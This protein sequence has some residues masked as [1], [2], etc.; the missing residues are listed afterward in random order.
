M[1]DMT[2][3]EK[4]DFGVQHAFK[5]SRGFVEMSIGCSKRQM[6]KRVSHARLM[7]HKKLLTVALKNHKVPKNND[8]DETNARKTKKVELDAMN[9]L[10]FTNK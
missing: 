4:D 1:K 9:H 3:K 6:C 10:T 5:I 7:T 8:T 2:E